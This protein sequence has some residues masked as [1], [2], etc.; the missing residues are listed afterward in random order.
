MFIAKRGIMA[1]TERNVGGLT[2]CSR[3]KQKYQDENGI[4]GVS[5]AA[6][7]NVFRTV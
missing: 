2:D 7:I 6:Q 3:L 1:M 5:I 4:V